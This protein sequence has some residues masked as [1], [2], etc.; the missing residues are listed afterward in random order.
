MAGS[1]QSPRVITLTTDFGAKDAF[2]GVM[3][4]VIL[5]INPQATIVDITHGIPQGDVDAA[6]FALDQAY[7]FFPSHAIHV[8]VVDPG[9]GTARRILLVRA[10]NFFFIA[11]DNAVLKYIFSR[12]P[13][14]AVWSVTNRE[15]FLPNTSQTFHGRDIFAPVAAHLSL[16]VSETNVGP[17]VQ[18]YL[19]DDI[20]L[21]HKLQKKI[22]GE[23]VYIDHFGNCISNISK[24]DFQPEQIS[25]INI[26]EFQFEALSQSYAEHDVGEPLAII[27]SHDHLEIA[28]RDRNAAQILNIKKGEPVELIFR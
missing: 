12:F 24:Y 1:E 21:P 16:G 19:M 9:V 14:A 7:S 25:E 2:V 15:Y 4:G 3:K 10:N 22:T 13:Q 5:S 23:I 26:K 27:G 20:V 28:V 8:V 17:R 6:A 11:P 18:D